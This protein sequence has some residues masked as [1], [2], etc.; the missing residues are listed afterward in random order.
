MKDIYKSI[1][2]AVVTLFNPRGDVLDNIRSYLPYVKELL[3][4][5]NSELTFDLSILENEY[6]L[7]VI[8]GSQ[9]LGIAKSL[10]LALEYAENKNYK[11]LLTMDQDSYFNVE[12]IRKFI[13]SF[14]DISHENLAI[15]TPL[16]NPQMIQ[17][18]QT[19]HS[20]KNFVM[21]SGNIINVQ[22]SLSIGGFDERLFIDEVDH[23]FCLRLKKEKYKIIQ[24]ENCYLNHT[25]GEKCSLSQKT[26]YPSKR[27]YYMSR[28]YLFLR[29][30]HQAYF[31]SFF[32]ERD[33]YLLKFFVKQVLY[34]SNTREHIKMLYLGV[35]DYRKNS[36][37]C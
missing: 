34:S 3:I 6:N 29:A 17:K 9:N 14:Q 24:N 12:E 16:H 18:N 4:V 1:D 22:K 20:S 27:L 30:K 13:I 33:R 31:P 19:I 11:W 2:I 23:D 28:N 25:L 5:Q 21:T 35:K 36:M 7:K 8:S 32:K 37:G 15:F 26:K 10:N